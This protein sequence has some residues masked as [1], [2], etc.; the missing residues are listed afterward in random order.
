VRSELIGYGHST[1]GGDRMKRLM[2][3]LALLAG[4][5]VS[6]DEPQKVLE[7]PVGRWQMTPAMGVIDKVEQPRPST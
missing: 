7:Q 6:H 5:C 1:W 3:L 4:G 2:V